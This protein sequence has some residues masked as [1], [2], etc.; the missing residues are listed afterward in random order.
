MSSFLDGALDVDKQDYL[1]RDSHHVGIEYARHIDRERLL[2]SLTI[3]KLNCELAITEKGKTAVEFLIM[4]RSAMFSEVYWHHTNRAATAMIQRGFLEVIKH[5]KLSQDEIINILLTS[6]DNEVLEYL[7]ING[8][9]YISELI[10][11]PTKW[12][13]RR[14]VYKR[15]LT[16]AFHYEPPKNF[17]YEKLVHQNSEKKRELEQKIVTLLN[18]KNKKLDVREHEIL[19]DIPLGDEQLIPV[20][21]IYSNT[22]N[23]IETSLSNVTHFNSSIFEK[24][25]KFTKKAR[26]FCHPRLRDEIIVISEDMRDLI[27]SHLGIMSLKE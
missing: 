2:R 13:L 3:S 16:F 26:I 12:D 6:N 4:S 5:K 9:D 8:P 1:A 21:V 7:I 15:I 17:V 24:F 19:I 10:P 11:N 23:K 27:G 14:Q 25:F 20:Q 18:K 22:E